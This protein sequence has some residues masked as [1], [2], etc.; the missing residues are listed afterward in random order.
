MGVGKSTQGKLLATSLGLPQLSMDQV[1]WDY[2]REIGYDAERQRAIGENEGF[3]GIY[4]YWKPFE[5]HAVERLLADHHDCVIDFGAG[6]SVFEDAGLFER[7]RRAVAPFSNVVL[8]LPSPDPEES[9][10]I[11]HTRR[12]GSPPPG[13]FDVNAHFIRHHSNYDLAKIVVYT[14]GKTPEE[15]RDSILSAIAE[16]T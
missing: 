2:Y 10:R 12:G 14:E 6:H 8:L 5:A 11:L 4:R 3:A 13:E 16:R 7:V 1:R 15:T 9:L